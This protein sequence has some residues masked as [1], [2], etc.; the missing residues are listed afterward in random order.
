MV[1]AKLKKEFEN[2]RTYFSL[3]PL[4]FIHS[5]Q[6]AVD[7]RV[8][9]V[10]H[11]ERTLAYSN[12]FVGSQDYRDITDP[13][14][15]RLANDISSVVTSLSVF[16]H[17]DH[18]CQVVVLSTEPQIPTIMVITALRLIALP[19]PSPCRVRLCFKETF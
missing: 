17:D 7:K 16:I 19:Y 12:T 2:D 10:V 6:H 8:T 14:R 3:P 15:A 4:T 13:H 11:C 5:E 18:T 9:S 1:V